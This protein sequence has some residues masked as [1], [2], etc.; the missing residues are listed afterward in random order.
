MAP[1]SAVNSHLSEIS[2]GKPGT[3]LRSQMAVISLGVRGH[4]LSVKLHGAAHAIGFTRPRRIFQLSICCLGPGLQ[5][6]YLWPALVQLS[7]CPDA[8]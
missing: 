3:G 4:Q 5:C 2:S 6:C 8:A 1:S 7:I